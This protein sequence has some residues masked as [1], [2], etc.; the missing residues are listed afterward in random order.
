MILGIDPGING[1]LA[2]YD[3]QHLS[4][5]DMPTYVRAAGARGKD[6]RFINEPEL[7]RLLGVAAMEG[8]E[9]LILEQVGG[10]PGQ[11]AASAFTFGRGVGVIIGAACAMDMKREEVA[12]GTWKSALK[13]PPDKRAARAR[14]SEIFPAYS[15]LW[16]LQKHDG[17]AEAA[18]IAYYGWQTKGTL[19]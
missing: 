2:R 7:A 17:R 4:V 14:A 12:S 1:A 19:G 13:V 5:L 6:R 8:C 11:G 18:L 10:I 9:W 3:G 16:P 15:G